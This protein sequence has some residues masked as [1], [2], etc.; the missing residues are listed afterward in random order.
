MK[1]WFKRNWSIAIILILTPL[2]LIAT[3]QILPTHDDWVGTTSPDF[4]PFFTKEHF[5]FYGFHWRPFDTWIGYIS[6]RNPQLL[7][8]AFNH[9]C[10]IIGHVL[11]TLLIYKLLEILSF[12]RLSRNIAT[13]FFFINPATMATVLAVD[14][15]NQ[16][17]ALL[18]GMLAFLIYIKTKRQKYYLWPLLVFIA[19]LAKENGLMW[20]LICP[21]LAYGFNFTDK[22]TLKRDVIVGIAIMVIYFLAIALLPK[23]M[24]IHPEYVPDNFKIIKNIVKFI[25]SAFITVDYIYLLHQPSRHLL[26]A[27]ISFLLATPFLYFAFISKIKL[28]VHKKMVYTFISLL[29]AVTPHLG[30]V[31]SMMHAYAGLAMIAIIIAYSISHI[32]HVKPVVITFI[33]W[34]ITALSIDSHLID[35]SI[36]SGLIGK[37]MAKEAIQKTGQPV[38][39]VYVII[40]EDDYPKLSS[41]CVIPNEAF[42]W[43]L[44]AQYETNYQWPK[45]IQDTTIS[46]S[47]HWQQEADILANKKLQE[48]LFDAVWIINHQAITVIKK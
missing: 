22:K 43:G 45:E 46:R 16:T 42:G 34:T 33:L 30:T 38:I 5:L 44:A 17:Y 13:L 48:N 35:S 10:V 4:T 9:L 19:A 1:E 20:A 36:K 21:I 18:W 28:F 2:L 12:T 15:Q 11:C 40:I 26:L 47:Q 32:E 25:F 6:G 29:I 23:N 24:I 7:F 31:F 3:I 14:S 41:F 37:Q 39:R 27:A 8:P